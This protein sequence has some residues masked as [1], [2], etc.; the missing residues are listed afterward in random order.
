MAVAKARRPHHKSESQH[1]VYDGEHRDS[2]RQSTGHQPSIRL[3]RCRYLNNFL[4][5]KASKPFGKVQ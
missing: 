4:V 2:E 1:R 5:L 3:M